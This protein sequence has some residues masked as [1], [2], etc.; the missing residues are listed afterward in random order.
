MDHDELTPLALTECPHCGAAVPAA[1]FCGS[2]GA[3]L[4]YA[5]DG[6]R[7]RHH[8]F[9]A[10]PEEP[11]L[12]VSVTTSLFPHLSPRSKL[13]FRAGVGVI[14]GLLVIFA[15][16]KLQA[17]MIAVAA[18]GFP[19]LFLLYVVEIDDP[20][21]S[22]FA[23][24]VAL[25]LLLGAILG[26]TW[27][28]VGGHYVD[29]AL[30]LTLGTTLT[31]RDAFV[32]AVVVPAVGVLLMAVPVT[33]LRIG[34][35]STESLDGFVV[36]A[37]GALAFELAATIE[38]LVDLLRQG[39]T[40]DL[41]FTSTLTQVVVRGFAGPLIAAM[42]IGLFGAALWTRR[43]RRSTGWQRAA[44]RPV[45]ALALALVVHIGLGY[46]DIAVLSD[47]ALLLAYVAAAGV[48]ILAV[49]VCLHHV[50]LSELHDVS[51]GPPS[52]CPHCR[53]LV[54]VM[55]FCPHCGVARHATAPRH[56]ATPAAPAPAEVSP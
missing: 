11:V 1:E 33:V 32:A 42:T 53:R 18:C 9:A 48:V 10:F 50:L 26:V 45:T 36:G 51:I 49:R 52:A 24:P 38:Q 17:P 22:S 15:L 4:T 43:H 47:L 30:S 41:S 31:G 16:A 54:P 27:A 40:S 19:I 39:Q 28:V 7:H 3:H 25:A 23:A 8:A 44:T 29:K 21:R 37:V 6:A 20:D 35:H 2:C 34:R 12:R 14:V 5:H 46:A 55:P 56:R 13:L